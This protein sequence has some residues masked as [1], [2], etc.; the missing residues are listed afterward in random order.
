MTIKFDSNDT[1]LVVIDPQNGFLS[2][3]VV[4]WGL[5]LVAERYHKSTLSSQY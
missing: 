3:Q 5:V 1:A 2:E 4:S